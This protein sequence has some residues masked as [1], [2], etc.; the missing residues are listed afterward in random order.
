MNDSSGP[1]AGTRPVN[2]SC[3]NKMV[4]P[5]AAPTDNRKPSPATSGTSRERKTTSSKRTARPTTMPR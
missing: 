5:N 2:P 1:G 4:T 3:Q